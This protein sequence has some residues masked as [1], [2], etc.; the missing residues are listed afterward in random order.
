MNRTML[1]LLRQQLLLSELQLPL[2]AAEL[3][4]VEMAGKLGA[5][6]RPQLVANLLLPPTRAAQQVCF[7]LYLKGAE[8]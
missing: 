6:W 5:G 1:Q 2:V 4:V 3:I 7:R 8:G